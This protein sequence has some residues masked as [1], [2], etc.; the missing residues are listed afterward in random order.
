MIQQT[1]RRVSVFDNHDGSL[2][3]WDE[4]CVNNATV[5]HVDA[6]HDLFTDTGMNCPSIGDYLRWALAEGVVREIYW[7]IPEPAFETAS[8][9]SNIQAHLKVLA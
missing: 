9:L 1:A 2:H 3:L 8:G 5:V 4:M 6:H 7:V